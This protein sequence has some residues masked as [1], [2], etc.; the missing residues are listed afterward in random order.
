MAS[1]IKT[2]KSKR[3]TLDLS[4]IPNGLKLEYTYGTNRK[5][6]QCFYEPAALGKVLAFVTR[7]FRDVAQPG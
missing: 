5:Y 4:P 1:K 2:K 6:T 3:V 7:K